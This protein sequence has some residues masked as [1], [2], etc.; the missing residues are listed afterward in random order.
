[1]WLTGDRFSHNWLEFSHMRSI[2]K[3]KNPQNP[4][5]HNVLALLSQWRTHGFKFMLCQCHQHHPNAQGWGCCRVLTH[6]HQHPTS[7]GSGQWQVMPDVSAR[8]HPPSPPYQVPGLRFK[9]KERCWEERNIWL[10]S[11]FFPST[12]SQ[13]ERVPRFCYPNLKPWFLCDSSVFFSPRGSST[14]SSPNS[15]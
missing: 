13:K 14:R 7:S 5:L 4:Q 15:P 12:T 11:F 1:M 10:I 3:E 8:G 2:K 6:L 9:R